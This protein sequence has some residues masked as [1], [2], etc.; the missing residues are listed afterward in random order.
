MKAV[1][2]TLLWITFTFLSG[3]FYLVQEGQGG[4]AERFPIKYEKRLLHQRLLNC[5]IIYSRHDLEGKAALY[6]AIYQKTRQLLIRSRR[7][8]EADYFLQA[9]LPLEQAEKLLRR[10][11]TTSSEMKSTTE[12]HCTN[13]PLGGVCI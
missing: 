12:N 2:L 13:R 8:Y 4:V 3:C 7:F 5:E 6:P 11:E 1:R 10:L 9:E